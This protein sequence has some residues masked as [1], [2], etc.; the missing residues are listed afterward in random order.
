[1]FV[2]TAARVLFQVVDKGQSLSSALPAAQQTIKFRDQ[3]SAAGDLLW[4]SC[5]TF[6]VWNPLPVG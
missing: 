5:A 2:P 3:A 6:L 4:R 1:M